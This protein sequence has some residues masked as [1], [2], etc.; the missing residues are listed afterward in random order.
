[1]EKI[2]FDVSLVNV[3]DNQGIPD[4]YTL[5]QNYP[6]PFNPVTTINYTIPERGFVKIQIYDAIGN[7]IATLVSS[8]KEAGSYNVTYDANDLA[9]GVYFYQLS[10]NSFKETK[11]LVLMK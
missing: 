7:I 1:M 4:S 2:G 6:N 11:K 10:V 9:S 5:S 8:E 3:N